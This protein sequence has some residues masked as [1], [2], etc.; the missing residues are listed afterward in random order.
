M[1]TEYSC[2][3]DE[4]T[5]ENAYCPRTISDINIC[6]IANNIT[7]IQYAGPC[8]CPNNCMVD[9]KHGTCMNGSC[10]CNV[11]W[12]GSDCSQGTTKQLMKKTNYWGRDTLSNNVTYNILF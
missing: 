10:Q 12:K 5:Y 11:G 4:V 2:G 3:Q 8:G 7:G 1:N 9:S 6:L